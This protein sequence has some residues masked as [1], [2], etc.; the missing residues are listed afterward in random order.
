MGKLMEKAGD[1]LNNDKMAE[2]GR[3]KRGGA[4]GYGD[5]SYGSSGRSDNY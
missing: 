1:M 3:E 4:G 5:D 2:K